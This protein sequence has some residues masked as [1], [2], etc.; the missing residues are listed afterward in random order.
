MTDGSHGITRLE[1]TARV[2][3]LLGLGSLLLPGSLAWGG[4]PTDQLKV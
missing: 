3:V 4:V 2:T 1:R